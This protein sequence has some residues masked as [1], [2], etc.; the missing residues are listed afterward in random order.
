MSET[1]FIYPISPSTSM[2]ENMDTFSSKGIKNGFGNDV[3]VRMMQSE[4][5]VAGAIHGASSN[6][7]LTS[8]FT[9]SQGLLL[10]IPNL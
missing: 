7:V 9:A 8:T 2:G 3:T 5:G 10:M 1:T 6:G 4:A